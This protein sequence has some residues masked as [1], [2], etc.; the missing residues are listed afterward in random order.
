MQTMV[1]KANPNIRLLVGHSLVGSVALELQKACPRL[2]VQNIRAPV[3]ELKGMM[4]IYSNSHIEGFKH[5]LDL[6]CV[7]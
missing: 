1:L 5:Y 7:F 2:T 4:P 3:L 6:V